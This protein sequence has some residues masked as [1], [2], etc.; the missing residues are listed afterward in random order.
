MS[1]LFKETLRNQSIHDSKPLRCGPTKES[2]NVYLVSYKAGDPSSCPYKTLRYVLSSLLLSANC[3][4]PDLPLGFMRIRINPN[5][6]R[7]Q[8]A[9]AGLRTPLPPRLKT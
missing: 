4:S 9:A 1:D 2:N 6:R 5:R 8:S 7:V 3:Q